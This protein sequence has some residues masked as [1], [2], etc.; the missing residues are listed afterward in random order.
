MKRLITAITILALLGLSGCDDKDA[1]DYANELVGVLKTYQVEVNKKIGAEKKSYKELA[2]TYAYARRVEMLSRLSNERL[3]GAD[4]LADALLADGN[5]TPSEMHKLVQD[6][7]RVEFD[8][9]REALTQESDGQAE[10]LA[11]LEAL[12][13]QAQNIAKLTKALEALAKPKGDI[14]KLKE[15]AGSVKEFKSKFDELECQQLAEEIACLKEEQSKI[16]KRTDLTDEQKKVK[17]D[18]LEVQI[19][20]LTDLNTEQKC[21]TDLSKVQCPDTKG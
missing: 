13:L 5:L 1:R 18:K 16:D 14:K 11:S 7:A 12:D 3:A 9:T 15:L 17:K 6:H 8:A 4:T 21:K 20:A 2:G 19:K 10:Y